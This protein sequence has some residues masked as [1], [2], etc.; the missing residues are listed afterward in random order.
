MEA[1]YSSE[2]SVD[3]TTRRYIPENRTLVFEARLFQ[4]GVSVF[5]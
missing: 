2:I 3:T 4:N 5:K 1:T